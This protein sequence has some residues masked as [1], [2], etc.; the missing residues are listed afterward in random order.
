[1]YPK[2]IRKKNVVKKSISTK[3]EHINT[4]ESTISDSQKHNLNINLNDNY[5]ESKNP[6]NLPI[7]TIYKCEFCKKKF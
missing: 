6:M 2:C 3:P 7:G 4:Q 1:M 5:E